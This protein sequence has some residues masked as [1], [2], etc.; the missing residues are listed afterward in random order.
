MIGGVPVKKKLTKAL[1]YLALLVVIVFG[2]QIFRLA[3]FHE[4]GYM[5]EGFDAFRLVKLLVMCS[6]LWSALV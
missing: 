4:I 2:S 5:F 3:D 1:I 6:F